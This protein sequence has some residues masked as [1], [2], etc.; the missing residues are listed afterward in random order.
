MA[1]DDYPVLVYKILAY[2]YACLKNGVKPDPAFLSADG[3][4]LGGIN[5]RYYGFI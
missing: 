3:S 4:Y 1:M 5:E 2:L